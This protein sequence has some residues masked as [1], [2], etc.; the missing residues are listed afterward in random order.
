MLIKTAEASSSAFFKGLFLPSALLSPCATLGTP[1]LRVQPAFVVLLEAWLLPVFGGSIQAC[2]ALANLSL[3]LLLPG[4]LSILKPL[5]R[6]EQDTYNLT[7]VA[8]DHGAPRHTATQVLFVQVIDVN[9]EAPLFEKD[10]YQAQVLENQN[11]GSTV[12]TVSASDRDQGG[13]H[14]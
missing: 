2:P 14:H 1:S 9:D 6:E 10:E 13:S 4:S 12:L 3:S 7:I 8:E 5:D 11:P